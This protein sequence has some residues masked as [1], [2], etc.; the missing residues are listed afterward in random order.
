LKTKFVPV[1]WKLDPK[2]RTILQNQCFALVVTAGNQSSYIV[3]TQYNKTAGN[4]V[5]LTR[6]DLE[7]D[8]RG[9]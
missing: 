9:P 4:T 6:L 2:I 5:L 3:Y 7:W 8:K 1:F